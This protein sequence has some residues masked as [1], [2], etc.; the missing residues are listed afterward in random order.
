M[1]SAMEVPNIIEFLELFYDNLVYINW[2]WFIRSHWYNN[3]QPFRI[4]YTDSGTPIIVLV[5]YRPGVT[6]LNITEKLEAEIPVGIETSY[7]FN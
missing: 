5:L 2:Y 1:L 3:N 4:T 6:P 7:S